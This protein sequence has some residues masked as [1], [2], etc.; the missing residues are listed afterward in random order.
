M[1]IYHC[2]WKHKIQTKEKKE[3]Y[4]HTK[5]NIKNKKFV[6]KNENRNKYI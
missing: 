3:N 6:K 1:K 2:E 5:G 4:K